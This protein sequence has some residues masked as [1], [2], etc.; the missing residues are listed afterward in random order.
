MN[1]EEEFC[2][3]DVFLRA[4]RFRIIKRLKDKIRFLMDNDLDG[5][6]SSMDLCFYGKEFWRN[7]ESEAF[8]ARKI[9][10][11]IVFFEVDK[12]G[13]KHEIP[14]SLLDTNLIK[15]VYIHLDCFDG[16]VFELNIDSILCL[17]SKKKDI[18]LK[19]L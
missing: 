4:K 12:D 2:E 7:K 15:A 18:V 5:P 10:D 9:S 19:N 8:I 14:D 11:R 17:E 13:K 6:L 16:T 3:M 1:W